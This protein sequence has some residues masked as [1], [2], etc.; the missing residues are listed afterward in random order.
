MSWRNALRIFVADPQTG[1]LSAAEAMTAGAFA[2]TS[3]VVLHAAF[4][5]ALQEYE[6]IGYMA[7]WALHGQASRL[8]T[9]QRGKTDADI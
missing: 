9:L 2:I 5:H 7:V 4:S 8:V 6:F 1:S 3:I